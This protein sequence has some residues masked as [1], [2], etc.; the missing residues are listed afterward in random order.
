[1]SANMCRSACHNFTQTKSKIAPVTALSGHDVR[2]VLIGPNAY[3]NVKSQLFTTLCISLISDSA[4]LE[5]IS[6]STQ[7]I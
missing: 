5:I 3:N 7:N 1:M 2:F 4:A 6:Y